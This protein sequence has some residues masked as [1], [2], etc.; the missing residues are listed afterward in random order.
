MSASRR[1]APSKRSSARAASS[2]AA[3]AASSA[4]RASRSASASAFS[5]SADDRR[6]RGAS[7]SAFST[8][9]ISARRF[10]AKTCGALSSSAR[11]RLASAMRWSS[12]AIWLRAPSRRS[13]Q[14]AGRWRCRQPA[15]GQFRLARDRLLLGAHLGELWR[16]C[17][18][19]RRARRRACFRVRRRAPARRA[20]ARLRLGG[21]RLVA[22]GGQAVRA[23]ASAESRATWRLR[24]RSRARVSAFGC[25]R[26][27]E[28]RL[29]GFERARACPRPRRARA[30]SSPSISA[31]RLR[32]AR[33]RAAPVGA[34]AAATKPSQRHRS[35]SRETSRWPGLSVARALRRRR[36]RP[37][38]SGPG[39]GPARPA[40]GRSAPALRR[41]AGSAGSVASIGARPVHRREASTGAS[42]SSPSAA[43]SAFS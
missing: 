23:S 37:R 11:S 36:A 29:R 32:C 18:R 2:R 6:R 5:A 41:L 13:L 38:R 43:P 9:P 1:L 20:R 17:R 19:C 21:A 15:V 30:R 42:R 40:P 35:P 4:A 12:V 8:S 39:G 28:G 10:S 22:A 34:W 33:R 7:A 27:L 26:R 31:R 25:G 14:P 3:L 16:A 24:S